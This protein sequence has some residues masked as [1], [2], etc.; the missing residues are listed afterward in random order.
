MKNLLLILLIMMCAMAFVTAQTI[1]Y[2]DMEDSFESFS[3][4]LAEALPYAST[5]GLN[6]SDAYLGGF[7]HFGVGV[8][9]GFVSLPSDGFEEVADVLGVELPDLVTSYGIGVPL[10]AYTFDARLG[11]PVLP[12]DVGVKGGALSASISD[13]GIDYLLLGG[14]VRWGVMKGGAIKP[15]ISI[16]LGYNY[17]SGGIYMDDVVDG[18]TFYLG[19]IDYGISGY[20]YIEISDGDLYYE[21]DSHVIDAKVQV[22]KGFLILKPSVGIGYSY[23]FTEAG[24]GIDATVSASDGTTSTTLTSDDISDIESVL[25]MDLSD[26]G[27]SIFT[28]DNAGALRLWG[29]C[30]F[31]IAVLKLDLSAVYNVT[32]QSLGGSL[33]ARIQL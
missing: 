9:V 11:I 14:D 16:G 32:S 5:T 21:W 27:L 19:D 10:P 26:T 20:D 17:L 7:P 28:E 25:G 22:S 12:I 4:D 8:T 24:G 18:E 6:W 3:S 15:D 30:Q 33:N 2:S 29:G 13:V 31:N 23:G 1:D